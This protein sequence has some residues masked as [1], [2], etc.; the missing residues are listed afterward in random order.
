MELVGE[1]S[2]R[3]E[4][5]YRCRTAL[6]VEAHREPLR[7]LKRWRIR[8]EVVT[9]GSRPSGS[10]EKQQTSQKSLVLPHSA[11]QASEDHRWIA[12]TRRTEQASDAGASWNRGTFITGVADIAQMQ[13]AAGVTMVT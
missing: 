9:S 5:R 2:T 4:A 1:K 6:E 3:G 8:N 10:G 7:D 11:S 13:A 12:E